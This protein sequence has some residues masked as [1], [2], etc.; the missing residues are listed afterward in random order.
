MTTA[1]PDDTGRTAARARRLSQFRT[2]GADVKAKFNW[3]TAL[4]VMGHL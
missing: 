1:Q 4:K 3:V 2:L